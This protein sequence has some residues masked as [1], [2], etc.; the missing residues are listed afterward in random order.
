MRALVSHTLDIPRFNK[1]D[2]VTAFEKFENLT[3]V[4]L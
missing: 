2:I 3:K 4:I 1:N